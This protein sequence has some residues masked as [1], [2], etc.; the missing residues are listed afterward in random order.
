MKIGLVLAGGGGKGGYQ[1]GVW[2]Y[3]KEI[4]LEKNISVISGTSVGG[5]N[6]VLMGCVDYK[7]AEKIWTTEIDD[8]IL[9][10][11]SQSRKDGALFSRTGLLK[12]I[13]DYV[14]LSNLKT[15][16]KQIYVTCYN[17]D[18]LIPEYFNLNKYENDDIKKFLCATSAIPIAFQN[19]KIYGKN[20]I[21]GGVKDNVPLRPLLQ[22][23]CTHA[24]VVNLGDEHEDYSGFD[25][26]TIVLHPSSNLGNLFSGTMDFSLENATKRINI[27]YNDCKNIYLIKDWNTFGGFYE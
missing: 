27:G 16:G 19:E 24:L 2:K 26:K 11:T 22:E 7:I 25:I 4:G 23:K 9:D 21:D 8:K 20:Y 18:G 12:I 15:S 5:L 14:N 6:A 10:L 13:K 1:I 3:L 17:T